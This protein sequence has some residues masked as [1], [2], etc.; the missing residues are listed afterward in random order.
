VTISIREV[1]FVSLLAVLFYFYSLFL[2]LIRDQHYAK[3]KLEY[4]YLYPDK[5][6]KMY[7]LFLDQCRRTYNKEQVSLIVDCTAAKMTAYLHETD[8]N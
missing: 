3:Q 1:I 2:D 8:P 6:T 4:I 7:D 5:D